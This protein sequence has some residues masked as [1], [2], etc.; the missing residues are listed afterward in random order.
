MPGTCANCTGAIAG[1]PSLQCDCCK[2]D[3][4]VACTGLQADDRITRTRARCI[5]IVCHT[6]SGNIEQLAD[7]KASFNEMKTSLLNK[8]EA[9]EQK[10]GEV[11]NSVTSILSQVPG[12]DPKE[13]EDIIQETMERITRSKNVIIRGVP[14]HF[15]SLDERK[16]HDFGKVAEI[17]TAVNSSAKPVSVIRLGKPQPNTDGDR[18]P[19]PLKLTMSDRPSAV[20]VLRNRRRLLDTPAYRTVT[21]QDDR[22]PSQ[23]R[24]LDE[25]RAGLQRR[26]DEGE[27]G[28][29][30]KYVKGVPEVVK[31]TPKK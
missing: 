12:K 21:L 14:E 9:L 8:I 17:L 18:R 24:Y 16:Q 10:F 7:L 20:A 15:G 29:T 5:K 11:S 25:L 30:I 27:Q 4:H 26:Q 6:C 13:R 31:V 19:R 22:T 2:R 28:L 1:K 23:I 3:I